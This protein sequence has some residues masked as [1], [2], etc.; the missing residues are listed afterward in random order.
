MVVW[1]CFLCNFCKC[2]YREYRLKLQNSLR[3]LTLLW[4]QQEPFLLI[5]DF[6]RVNLGVLREEETETLV[7]LF[8]SN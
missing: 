2:L 5:S 7:Q 1:K 8:S 3:S 6:Q 4:L